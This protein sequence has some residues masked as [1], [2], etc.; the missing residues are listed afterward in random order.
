MLGGRPDL[1]T[2]TS[3]QFAETVPPS[4]TRKPR[5]CVHAHAPGD[6]RGTSSHQRGGAPC[7]VHELDTLHFKSWWKEGNATPQASSEKR[8]VNTSAFRR[9]TVDVFFTIEDGSF[10]IALEGDDK[11]YSISHIEGRNGPLECW[12]LYV[13]ARI[14]MLGRNITLKQVRTRARG[15]LVWHVVLLYGAQGALASHGDGLRRA[16]VQATLATQQWIDHHAVRL[17]KLIKRMTKELVKYDVDASHQL[18]KKRQQAV[19]KGV[20]QPP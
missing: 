7:S 17:E 11:V 1:S 10:K 15:R 13:G 19:T 16:Y 8:D 6:A 20:R 12:D 14:N 18:S 3:T 2:P 5:R 4:R 9:Q